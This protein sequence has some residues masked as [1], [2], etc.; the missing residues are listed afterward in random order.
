MGTLS[1]CPW[2][3]HCLLARRSSVRA[4][5]TDPV[6]SHSRASAP[7]DS[8]RSAC[9]FPPLAASGFGP[10]GLSFTSAPVRDFEPLHPSSLRG[11][12]KLLCRNLHIKKR[13]VAAPI[14]EPLYKM[15]LF[16]A[17]STLFHA[18]SYKVKKA[19]RLHC[20][21]LLGSNYL[22][23]SPMV[24]GAMPAALDSSVSMCIA[25]A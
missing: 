3:G 20:P 9:L 13:P 21:F 15:K 16:C 7:C 24:P 10:T 2:Q 11:G 19:V 25:S 8:R 18:I 4:A 14:S 1:P 23:T 6:N 22:M 17:R 12:I 5:L